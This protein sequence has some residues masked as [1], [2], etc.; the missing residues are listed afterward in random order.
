VAKFVYVVM[1]CDLHQ[2]HLVG[3]YGTQ[4]GAER[5]VHH[6]ESFLDATERL[7]INK[8]LVRN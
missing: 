6:E 1:L 8:E 4:E 3:V 7:I 2:D 5:Y